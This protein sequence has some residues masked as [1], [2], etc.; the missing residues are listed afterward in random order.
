MAPAERIE[1]GDYV[2]ATKWADGGLSDHWCVGV[3]DCEKGGRHFVKDANGKQFR[4]NGF[5]RVQKITPEESRW[6]LEIGW[7]L[8][9]VAPG[10]ATVWSLLSCMSALIDQETW[11]EIG[12]EWALKNSKARGYGVLGKDT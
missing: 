11:D 5:R 8:E 10:A 6:L 3:Y 4:F 9:G 12:V 7:R 2:V 1:A